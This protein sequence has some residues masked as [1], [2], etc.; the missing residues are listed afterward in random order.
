MRHERLWSAHRRRRS[1]QLHRLHEVGAGVEAADQIE[2]QHAAVHAVLASTQLVLRMRL[3]S[4][5][6]HPIH[7]RVGFECATHRDRGRSLLT[8]PRTQRAQTTNRV[9]RI[10]R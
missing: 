10:E 9:Q 2:R 6:T 5:M 8:Q 7:R 4:G 3:E 1:T